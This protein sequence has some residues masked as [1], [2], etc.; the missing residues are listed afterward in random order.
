MKTPIPTEGAGTD[1]RED[2]AVLLDATSV[3]QL[4][5]GVGR[6]VDHLAAALAAAGVR[7]TVVCQQR[8]V[9]IFGGLA[10]DSRVVAVH[11]RWRS[12]A[13]RMIWEQA[14]FP[15][16]ISRLA[17]DV[18]HSPHYTM[19]LASPVPVVVTLH[20]ATFFSHRALHLGVKGRFFRSWTRISLRRAARCVVPSRATAD[21]LRRHL[22][23]RPNVIQVAHHGVDQR[24]FHPPAE[25]DIAELTDTLSLTGRTWIAFLGTLEP[26]KNVPALIRGYIKA[27]SG[28]VDA[29]VLVLAGAAGWDKDIEPALSAVPEEL[30]VIRPG[31]LPIESL[32]ALLGGSMLVCYPSLG[33]GFGLPVLE[34]MACRSTVLT[35]RRLSLPE[36]GG[37]AVAYC[38]VQDEQIAGALGEL[39]A[40]PQ[41]RRRLADAAVKRAAGFTWQASAGEH[42]KAYR[43]AVGSR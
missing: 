36:V 23:V 20:D 21:Q 3:P 28:R 9:E 18:V 38:G 26:R 41:S 37:D 10:P 24:V 19:P 22:R 29:P 27:F 8:D 17:V 15:R 1:V 31:H 6:Y 34:A 32:P 25:A 30:S 2:P 43:H 11:R 39:A 42:L 7:L 40:D 5:G 12:R 16:L 4:R 13:G 35:T 14:A 33:E